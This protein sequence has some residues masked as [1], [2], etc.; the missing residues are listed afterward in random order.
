MKQRYSLEPTASSNPLK[1]AGKKIADLRDQ[2][3]SNPARLRLEMFLCKR[4][5]ELR[6]KKKLFT[7][8]AD[9][10]GFKKFQSNLLKTNRF[11]NAPF[12]VWTDK[13][14]GF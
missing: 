11:E 1:L 2:G 13:D 14:E 10:N 9:E 12:L 3:T 4:T 8:N 5:K 7:E 6:Q